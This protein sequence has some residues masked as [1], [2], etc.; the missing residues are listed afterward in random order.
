[1][2]IRQHCLAFCETLEFHASEDAHVLPAIGEHQP[3][4]R[5]A[6]D[7]LRAEHRT[8]ARTKE[9]I[10]TAD[11]GRLRREPARMSREPIAHLDHE[12]ETVL[13]ARAEIPLPA[14]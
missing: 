11:A 5:A 10:G 8:V 3:H 4:L 7:R 6:L 1:M 12:E 2:Q 9:E 13:P 14:R